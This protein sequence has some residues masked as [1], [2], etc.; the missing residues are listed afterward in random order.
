MNRLNRSSDAKVE[1]DKYFHGRLGQTIDSD[2]KAK[3]FQA[4][5][6]KLLKTVPP[7]RRSSHNTVGYD[8]SSPP[9]ILCNKISSGNWS[10]GKYGPVDITLVHYITVLYIN[11]IVGF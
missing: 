5:D 9:I 10:F 1:Y 2:R 3:N 6:L 8:R 11:Q 4:R 7:T